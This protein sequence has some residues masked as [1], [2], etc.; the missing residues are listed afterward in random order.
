MNEEERKI[1]TKE[2]IKGFNDCA[3]EAETMITG[4]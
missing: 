4:G 2:M 3:N 1:V